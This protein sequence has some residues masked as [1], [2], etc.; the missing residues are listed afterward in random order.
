[1]T[2]SAAAHLGHRAAAGSYKRRYHKGCGIAYAAGGVLIHLYAGQ[3]R[4]IHD[5][6]GMHHGGGELAHFA[7]CHALPAHRHKP[8]RH[9]VIGYIARGIFAD[10]IINFF[11]CMGFSLSLIDYEIYHSHISCLRS[12]VECPYMAKKIMINILT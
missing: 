10:Y 9:L 1:M 2:Q 11:P 7:L 12:C 4:K 6:A 8:R 5:V 3:V